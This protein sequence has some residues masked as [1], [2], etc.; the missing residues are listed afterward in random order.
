MFLMLMTALI[1]IL[2]ASIVIGFIWWF[3][4]PKLHEIPE[5]ERYII[6]EQG[7]FKRIVGPGP[8][9]IWEGFENVERKIQGRNEP[10][11]I[12]LNDLFIYDIPFGYKLNFWSRFNP[13]MLRDSDPTLMAELVQLNENER[14]QQIMVKVRAA[15]VNSIVQVQSAQAKTPDSLIGKVL[16]IVPGLDGYNEIMEH[17]RAELANTLLTIGTQLDQRQPITVPKLYLNPGIV[18]IL[19]RE[20]IAEHIEKI[21]PDLSNAETIQILSTVEGLTISPMYNIS[22]ADLAAGN[23]QAELDIR[24][25][26]NGAEVRTR[27][28]SGNRGASPPVS[29]NVSTTKEEF[30]T[31]QQDS[32]DSYK[33]QPADLAV[34]KRVA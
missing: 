21:I 22:S 20:R 27:I 29:E 26:E 25:R 2:I 13:T 9:W 33:L 8:V 18:N 19:N 6:Y 15:V 30:V 17:I 31:S 4:K 5:E 10:K 34:L 7:L 11:N 14:H 1:I 16:L 24:Q 12:V 23:A 32:I 28:R 3:L